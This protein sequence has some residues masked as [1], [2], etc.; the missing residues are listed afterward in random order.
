MKKQIR[1]QVFETNSSSSHSL[2]MGKGDLVAQPFS[3]R[4]LRRGEVALSVG[5]YGWE[6]HRYYTAQE[7]LNYLLTQITGGNDIPRGA[8]E[9]NIRELIERDERIAML[10]RVVK[11]F[12]GC[13]VVVNPGSGYIDHDS[14]GVGMEL[15]N[16]EE[17]LRQFLF[18]ETACIE[19]S[20]DNSPG[21][22]AIPTDKGDEF[23]YRDSFRDVP[24]SYVPVVLRQ[25][26][27][28]RDEG[29]ATV[30][31][32]LLSLDGNSELLNQILSKGIATFADWDCLDTQDPFDHRD[33]VG[34]SASEVLRVG[35]HE[36]Y[37]LRL[38]PQFKARHSYKEG[39]YD[40]RKEVC[41][42]TI[43]VPRDVAKALKA[44]PTD[45]EAAHLLKGARKQLRYWKDRAAKP[46]EDGKVDHWSNRQCE[47]YAR[48]V[49]HWEAKLKTARAEMRKAARAAA[50]V[51]A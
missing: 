51:Q 30:T 8:P 26:G 46:S 23:F 44:L 4:V 36:T 41:S 21:P 5:E 28:W 6:Y 10:V 16:N 42:I 34:Y 43:A 27:E 12:T 29:L 37:S 3:D 20:N 7:K 9:D 24:K 48:Q 35:R 13:D 25:V 33:L 18:D 47:K 14:V 38:S 19:T 49:A 22:W 45:G 1:K 17:T 32:G 31:G 2:T 50:K 15:F 39:D 11:D 40:N